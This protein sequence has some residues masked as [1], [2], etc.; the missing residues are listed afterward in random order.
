M[1]FSVRFSP[2]APGEYSSTLHINDLKVTLIGSSIA[3]SSVEIETPGGW[4]WLKAGEKV[5][6][7]TVERRSKLTRRLRITPAAPAS[8][9][10]DGFRLLPGDEI[11]TY[12][13]EFVS[14]RVGLNQGKLQ[15][16]SRT[17][18]LEVTVTDFPAPKPSI[19][20]TSETGTA[21]QVKFRVRL[22]EPARAEVVGLFTL[23]FTPETG[24]PDDGAVLLLPNA[25]RSLTVRFGEGAVESDEMTLQTGTTAGVVRLRVVIGN[26]AAEETIRIP[27][28]PVVLTQ[29]RAAVASANA[30][31]VLTGYDTPRAASRISFTFYLKSGQAAAP[32]RIDVDVRSAFTDYYKTV[33]GS[34]FTLRAHFPV[35]GTHTELESVE[36]EVLNSAGSSSTGRLRFE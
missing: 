27:A 34:A 12:I 9:S 6:L 7:G 10:G 15:V 31:V 4:Q 30:E 11:S 19:V 25:V 36:V 18:P 20:W 26:N 5:N 13:V 16:E 33:S 22:S 24:L 23:S 28:A 14:D 3:A 2:Q 21:K 1:D 35:S 17:F 32:G 29:A 8:I